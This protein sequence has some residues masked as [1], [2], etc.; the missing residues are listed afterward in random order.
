[1]DKLNIEMF[2]PKNDKQGG[3]V[4]F[5]LKKIDCHDTAM[6]LN[7]EGIAIRSGMHCAEPLISKYNDEGLTRASFYLYNTIEEVEYFISKLKEI[8]SI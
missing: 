5:N 8:N 1:M 2:C 3:I 7:D 6:L 4:L